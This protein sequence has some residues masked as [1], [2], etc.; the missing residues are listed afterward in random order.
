VI[1]NF[2][3]K[4]KLVVITGGAGLLGSMHAEAIAE[5]GGIPLLFDKSDEGV[6]KII[7]NIKKKYSITPLFFRGDVTKENNIKSLIKFTEKKKINIYGLINNAA[8]NPPIINSKINSL[9]NYNLKNWTRD[10]NIGLTGAFLCSRLIG[11]KMVKQKR[12]VIINISSDLGIISP[13]QRLYKSKK[14]NF[15]KPISYSVVKHGIIG[16]TKYL[17]TY[18]AK[19]GIRTNCLCPGGVY[20]NQKKNFVTKVKKLI[21]MNRMANKYEYKGAIQFMISEASSYMNGSTLVI[22]GGR[23]IW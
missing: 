4:K 19:N 13:D 18:W 22:D 14:N 21:P 2:L 5:I 7:K 8:S 11:N 3:I 23:T 12:G 9:S 16:L 6:K 17:A 10:I 20:D 1:K 15:E